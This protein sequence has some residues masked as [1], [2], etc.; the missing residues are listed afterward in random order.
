M[1]CFKNFTYWVILSINLLVGIGY[2]LCA[3]SP[4]I[5]PVKHPVQACLGLFF[6]IFILLNLI[7]FI[8]WL[9]TKRIY[10]L[11][12]VIFLI[13]GW[14]SLRAYSPLGISRESNGGETIKLLTYNVQSFHADGTEDENP[15]LQ[16]LKQSNADIICLQ[17]Y[18]PGY[19]A[20]LGKIE[21]VLSDYPYHQVNFLRGD[22]GLACY[23]RYPILSAQQIKYESLYNGSILYKLKI[24]NDTVTLINNHLESNKLDANDRK[25]YND[26][27]TSP[28]E[29]EV[30]TGGKYLLRKLADAVAIRALQADSIAAAI[31]RHASRY[32]LVCGDF[33]DS[34]ISYAHRVIGK[35]LTDIYVKAGFG[36]GFTYNQNHFYFRIDHLFSSAAFRILSC[37]VDHSIQSSD[38]YPVW[39]LLEK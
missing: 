36:P 6:P 32:T 13:S 28:R 25:I 22:Y 39:C 37:K 16:Y 29:E 8:F 14:D 5:S 4:Y 20:S 38:H 3:Y 2:L 11:V 10:A 7:F 31:R 19:K 27:L 24:G 26:L 30:S 33:N 34:P 12:S 15:I 17:E 21:Q 18:A 9:I 35:G 23:S 1:K